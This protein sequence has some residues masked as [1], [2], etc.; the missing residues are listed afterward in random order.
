MDREG[1]SAKAVSSEHYFK[2]K[3]FIIITIF[4]LDKERYGE[5]EKKKR[6]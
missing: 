6:L 5:E 3:Y 2:R 4:S 1:E